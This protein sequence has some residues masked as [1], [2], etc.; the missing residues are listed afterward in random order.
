MLWWIWKCFLPRLG[1]GPGTPVLSHKRNNFFAG[2]PL[3]YPRE[4]F[5]GEYIS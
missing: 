5:D 4:K 3:F 1:F 2:T